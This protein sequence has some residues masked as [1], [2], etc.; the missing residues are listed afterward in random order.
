M[1]PFFG[2]T[3]ACG[4]VVGKAL[5]LD[6]RGWRGARG[7]AHDCDGRSLPTSSKVQIGD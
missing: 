1:Q 7:L 3:S 6:L 2:V 4:E 5:D